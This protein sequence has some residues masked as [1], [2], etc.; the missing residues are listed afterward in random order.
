MGPTRPSPQEA[1]AAEDR[2]WEHRL[3]A[4]AQSLAQAQAEREPGARLDADYLKREAQAQAND[5]LRGGVSLA[6]ESG[7]P[8]LRNLQGAVNVDFDS[9]RSSVQLN[10]IDEV[11]RAGPATGLVQV[12]A[13]NQ[14]SR[15]T[16]NV[17][18]VYRHEV[19]EALMVGANGFLDYEFG[20]Q[21]LRG[22]LGIE[23]I[24]PEFS[25]HGNVYVPISGWKGAKRDNRREEKPASGMDVGVQYSPA[26][27][28][29]LSL[30]TSYFRWN[31]AHV[32]YYDSGRSQ[33]GAKGFK[34]G[35]EYRPVPVLSLG[36]E[37]TQVMGGG[38][39]T[40]LQLGLSVNL[41]EPLSKQL[42]RP[43]SDAPVFSLDGRR[44]TLVER[45]NRI[46]LK[47][48]RKQIVLPLTV[49][50]VSTRQADGRITISGLTHAGATVTVRLPDGSTGVAGADAAGRFTY[51]SAEDQ[52]SGLIV[53]RA[54]NAEG[55]S[56]REVS[57]QYVDEVRPGSLRVAVTSL[58]TQPVVRS[59]EVSGRTEPQ[60]DVQV[61]FPNGESIAAKADDQGMFKVRSKREVK[62]GQVVVQAT[63]PQTGMRVST[64]THYQPPSVQAP[65]IETVV[66]EAKTG[67]VTV[68]GKADPGARVDVRF[69]DGS[70]Q[71]TV[72]GK[73]GMYQVVSAGDM[74]SGDI[75]AQATG[76]DGSTSPVAVQ[77][78]DDAQDTT[79]PEA[80]EI[81]LITTD[82][83]SG[84]VAV[85]GRAE[86]GADVT[87][88]FP[89]GTV[90]RVVAADDGSYRVVSETDMVA[91][92]IQVVAAD[93]AGNK[94][95]VST[96]RYVDVVDKTAPAA[97][98]ITAVTENPADGRLTVAGKAEPGAQID[99]VFPDGT[100]AQ[101]V[102]GDDGSYEATSTR[103]MVS[104]GIDV[105]AKDKVGNLSEVTTRH[106]DDRVDKTA[107]AEPTIT[108]VVTDPATGRVTVSGKTEPKAQ[109]TVSFPDSTV[110]QGVAGDDGMFS[111]TSAGDMVGGD[112]RVQAVDQAGNQ[113][114]QAR[115][116]YDDAP[117]TTPPAPP[118]ITSVVTDPKTGR[119]TVK[120]SSE[121]GA[122][123]TVTFP[124][125]ASQKV[126]AG[127]DGSY[128]AKSA[129]DVMT[130]TIQ[131]EAAD[132]AGNKSPRMTHE[133]MDTVDKTAPDVDIDRLEEDR[134]TGR[135]TVIGTG[136]P[137]ARVMVTFPD[138]STKTGDI[139]A[140]GNFRVESDNDLETGYIEVTSQDKAGNT[141]RVSRVLHTDKV[142]KTAPAAPIIAEVTT[143]PTS[144]R[145]TVKG[146]TER[147]AQVEIDF[148]DGSKQT[149]TADGSGNFSVTS[150]N[151]QPS[152]QITATAS[153]KAR[154][155]SAPA[156]RQ[157]TDTVDKD[158]PDM[159]T[160][161]DA[162]TD[163]TTGQV[164]VT[165]KA[166]AEATV[167]VSFPGGGS[168]TVQAGKDGRYSVQSDDDVPAGTITVTARDAAGNTSQPTKKNYTDSF[169]QTHRISR[170]DTNPQNGIVTV[171]GKAQPNEALV[172]RLPNGDEVSLSA[173]T[174]GSFTAS[175][176]TDVPA[177]EVQLLSR[178]NGQQTVLAK[179]AYTDTFTKGRSDPSLST[180]IQYRFFGVRPQETSATLMSLYMA[181]FRKGPPVVQIL[182]ASQQD[183]ELAKR[184]AKAFTLKI[185]PDYNQ[186]KYDVQV[187]WPAGTFTD[188]DTGR[189]TNLKVKIFDTGTGN[190]LATRGQIYF[191]P[192][193]N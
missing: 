76:Q 158:A 130:G 77:A 39:Q 152:G 122:E 188:A 64:S 100:L 110:A 127:A 44:H 134:S 90:Q 49:T 180:A 38:G 192:P 182:D 14:N 102:A 175:S 178:A 7:L 98:I 73:D 48:R 173:Q 176:T 62:Q 165:G 147:G 32:D 41:S 124:G 24:A 53:L 5:V 30:K 21:H 28:P 132:L 9:G 87:V 193:H 146:Q 56:S 71:R 2:S 114:P 143:D 3:A 185:V 51:L 72:A 177:G 58:V 60:A 78:Y 42:R 145:V 83:A 179:R 20:K 121:A 155:R 140:S 12:G 157:Y 40:R 31:G 125:G 153:D 15:P 136:E 151:D 4:Q 86:R 37:Q 46:V 85:N 47:T 170:L 144:G 172:L 190:Y 163:M 108:T 57:Y 123:V 59:L 75:R 116:R 16:G 74:V 133:Y 34:V 156:T 112:I 118:S 174:D 191:E 65:T 115:Q 186:Q 187:S 80:P 6:R 18:A 92:D 94:S 67:R 8:F 13:H 104:G 189:L 17:G 164:T 68:T 81:R 43:D 93:A 52:P 105:R 128:S 171:S 84:R 154:N 99:I 161:A 167:T 101:V 61:S 129:E 91:G 79:P 97:P 107:P 23:A 183:K 29:G 168:K 11:F 88:N 50:S 103:D 27:A 162:V 82:D 96:H 70:S 137:G 33:A 169:A 160:I 159:P 142:D 10:T 135:V 109:V 181:T 55:D 54:R 66:T 117:D 25:L 148:P 45:E 184:A 131:V 106:F 166:E 139:D 119:V 111:V 95:A 126:R 141:S 89:D 35:V 36:L 1:S 69:P 26:F 120:G 19:H 150:A 149:G 63:H 113:S 22:S 138:D